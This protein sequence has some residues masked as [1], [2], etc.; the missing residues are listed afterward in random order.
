MTVLEGVSEDQVKN[1]L[2]RR[3][4]RLKELIDV[5]KL[6]PKKLERGFIKLLKDIKKECQFRVL[7]NNDA[8]ILVTGPTGEG[9]TSFCLMLSYFLDPAFRHET[10]MSLH[11]KDRFRLSRELPRGSV[12]LLEEIEIE[13]HRMAFRSTE[14]I[15]F[16]LLFMTNRKLKHINIAN[17]PEVMDLLEYLFDKRV[18]I[19]V[20]ILSKGLAMVFIAQEGLLFGNH[21]GIDIDKL[22]KVSKAIRSPRDAQTFIKRYLMKRPSFKGFIK[23]P[24]YHGA[25]T[26]EVYDSYE[27]YIQAEIIKYYQEKERGGSSYAGRLNEIIN[28]FIVNLYERHQLKSGEIS[29]LTTHEASPSKGLSQRTTN[30]RLNLRGIS[31]GKGG[32]RTS[33]EDMAVIEEDV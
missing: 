17:L 4:A 31:P 32:D 8:L 23:V 21:F 19:W 20:H 5:F 9:K 1:L 12:H 6:D 29:D 3:E 16:K 22:K 14:G 28:N 13:G 2:R 26:E 24:Q 10:H 33:T 18:R 30:R 15:N 11:A 25:F 7:D 27:E